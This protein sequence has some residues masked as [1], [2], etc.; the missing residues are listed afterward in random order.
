MTAW[1]RLAPAD[2]ARELATDPA[3]GLTAADAARRLLEHGPN[4]L[5]ERAVKGPWSIARDQLTSTMVVV[6]MAAAGISALVGDLVDAAAILAIVILNAV[7]GFSQEYRAERSMAALQRMA[8]PHVRV[9]R[10]GSIEEIAAP[11]L[12]PGDV[13]LLEAGNVVPADLR[14]IEVANLRTQEAA[15]TGE[16]EPVEKSTEALPAA[17]LA[18]ADRRNMAFMG[19]LVAHGRGVALV[20][21]TGMRTELGHVATL[22]QTVTREPTPLQRRLDHLGRRLAAI[23]LLIV[24][25]IFVLGLAR[26]EELR[27]MFLTAVSMAVAAVPEGLP[28]VVTIA[29]ALGAQRMLARNALI[30]KLAAVE[31]L[32]SVTVICSDKTGTLTQNRMTVAVLE[33]A[34]GTGRLETRT[35]VDLSAWMPLPP[36]VN[37]VPGPGGGEREAAA[38]APGRGEGALVLLAAGAALCNDASHDRRDGEAPGQE[39]TLGDPTEVALVEAAAR[40]GLDKGRLE[41][42]FPRV[43]ELPFESDRKRMTTVHAIPENGSALAALIGG[44]AGGGGRCLSLTK[45]A[46]D[47]LLS[48]SS[49][50][51]QEGSAGP[52]DA[53]RRRQIEEAHDRLAGDGMRVLGLALRFVPRPSG[54]LDAIEIER[55]LVFVGLLG[56]IDPPRPEAR[57]AVDT[58]FAAGIRPVLITGDHP[59]TARSIARELG[60]DAGR[61]VSGVDLDRLSAEELSATLSEASVFARV[62]PAH[63]LR[64][65]DAL[66]RQGQIVAMT[67]DGVNDAPA[68]KR[69]DIGVAMGIAGTDVSKEAADAVLLD[70]N[71]AT[72]VAAVEEGRVIY[73]NV[74]KFV[75]YLLTTN[76]A[77]LLLMLIAPFAGM[78]LPLLPLQILWINLVTDGPPA[79]TLALEPAEP[80]VMERPPYPPAE[81]IFARGLG[82]HIVWVGVLMAALTLAVGYLYWRAGDPAWQ[83]VVFTTAA[84]A[85]MGHVLGIRVTGA[86]LWSAGLFSNTWL[87]AAVAL[88]VLLQ[89]AVVYVPALQE[90]FSTRALDAGQIAASV[91][92][93][94]IVLLA[95]EGEKWLSR[96]R[97]EARA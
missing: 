19:T 15:L 92:V 44:A 73:D 56:L 72:I 42:R 1:H 2:A 6:L 63:K 39:H 95:V 90:I 82:V 66:Q 60:I 85:Q 84:L 20:V 38:K 91:A 87:A 13:V 7:L 48:V 5:V 37:A 40:L 79:L 11:E 4:A 25:V 53:A 88:T 70:D 46:V 9:R 43:G 36:D 80:G 14:L 62:S 24:A 76:S 81:S 18:V 35:A 96:R 22:L 93:G 23:A 33:P 34:D 27:L 51:W 57:P 47:G 71:F 75:R 52:L 94:G 50:V 68:L 41:Q 45:G 10:G 49:R 30:R 8:V 31:A 67:G 64:I 77:E 26:G 55:E 74:R 69:A 32:G 16:S 61:V 21:A 59:L 97:A 58:C 54:P 65:V 78:P 12:V 17:D 86:S 83:T 29:L 3:R 28:A 89:A